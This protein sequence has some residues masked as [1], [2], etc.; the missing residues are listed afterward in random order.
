MRP[1]PE[2]T[3]LVMRGVAR[4]LEACAL[5]LAIA[6]S[7]VN[8]GALAG[9]AALPSA[10]AEEGWSAEFEAVCSRTQDA[11]TLSDDELRSLVL[12]AD[13]LKPTIDALD[14]SR[15]KVYAKRLRMC[16]DLYAFVLE[17]RGRG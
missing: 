7:I 10:R 17:S 12:R 14:E 1:L 3:P 16:R 9:R 15:R 5:A 13:A 8:A 2:R 6:V 4:L 11:M